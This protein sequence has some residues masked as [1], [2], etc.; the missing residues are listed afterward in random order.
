MPYAYYNCINLTGKPIIGG[1][2]NVA[3]AYYNCK[4]LSGNVYFTNTNTGSL[5]STPDFN[6]TG[7]FGNR[8]N[9]KRLNIYVTAST[10]K[11]SM[12]V[13]LH[14]TGTDSLVG[15][16]ITWTNRDSFQYNS[17]YNIYIYPVSN[18]Q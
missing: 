11:K 18:V 10:N 3:Y 13:A 16:S 5:L 4:G 8:D 14:R 12:N 2:S 17:I 9:S 1:A 7:C 6:V 15:Q